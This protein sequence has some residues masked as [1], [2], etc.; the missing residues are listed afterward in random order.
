MK[1]TTR[2][3]DIYNA[4][5]YDFLRSGGQFPSG[6]DISEEL[7]VEQYQRGY[8]EAENQL[9]VRLDEVIDKAKA[10]GELFDPDTL[11]KFG[12]YVG[13]KAYTEA[14]REG[15][16][17][18]ETY[19]KKYLEGV[20]QLEEKKNTEFIDFALHGLDEQEENFKEYK[21]HIEKLEALSKA[22]I[23]FRKKVAELKGYTKA[24]I[25]SL[26]VKNKE[27]P[28]IHATIEDEI[29]ELLDN[30]ELANEDYDYPEKTKELRSQIKKEKEDIKG[31]EEIVNK[32][33]DKKAEYDKLMQ[34]KIEQETRSKGKK[35]IQVNIAN[36]N[37][38]DFLTKNPVIEAIFNNLK[39]RRERLKNN[40]NK[41]GE[42]RNEFRNAV[43]ERIDKNLR[44]SKSPLD[45]VH[46]GVPLG[47]GIYHAP[48]AYARKINPDVY[49]PDKFY[50]RI[51]E[52]GNELYKDYNKLK[53]KLSKGII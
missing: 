30:D 18:L 52:E 50:E 13:E 19:K 7:L 3:Y 9:N 14:E 38:R 39:E 34:K 31:L 10:Q 41:L 51:T 48:Y 42:L 40:E 47:K 35:D 24:S 17:R 4:S 1:R 20:K 25:A 43:K 53:R 23:D 36:K 22:E 33:A 16:K 29:D 49:S 2:Y 32:Q 27:K 11:K 21:N 44:E 37:L 46:K 6:S 8:R 15:L 5:V 12:H 26:K 28:L 45:M